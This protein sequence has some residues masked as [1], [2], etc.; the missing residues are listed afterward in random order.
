VAKRIPGR[1]SPHFELWEFACHCGKCKSRK[2]DPLLIAGLEL[3]RGMV[4]AHLGRDTPLTIKSGYRCP[5]HNAS[6]PGAAPDSQH[7]KARAADVACPDGMQL[8]VFA[9][10]ASHVDQFVRGGIGVYY[11]DNFVHVDVRQGKARWRVD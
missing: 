6:L 9:D 8:Q 10:L 4:S 2:P 3:W 7:L 11:S 5:A 1:L